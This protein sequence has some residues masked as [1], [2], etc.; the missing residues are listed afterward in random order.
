MNTVMRT[1]GG[2]IGG[3]LLAVILTA[4]TI[5]GTSVPSESAYTTMF[6]LCAVA[7]ALA[8]AAGLLLLPARARAR[9]EARAKV[10]G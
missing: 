6:W 8:G 10:A 3:Q 9:R 1:V 7:A 5:A 2:V 4:D